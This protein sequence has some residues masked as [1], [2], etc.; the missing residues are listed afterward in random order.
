ME[1]GRI[2]KMWFHSVV[3]AF[4]MSFGWLTQ[5]EESAGEL[6]LNLRETDIFIAGY[7]GL[8]LKWSYF[9]S[10]CVTVSVGRLR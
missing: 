4:Q 10:L 1:V 7:P 8:S 5:G 3:V 9:F 2:A 6:E